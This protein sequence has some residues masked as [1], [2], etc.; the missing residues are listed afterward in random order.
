MGIE[1][2]AGADDSNHAGTNIKGEIALVT[3]SLLSE[4]SVVKTFK[5]TREYSSALKWMA[6]YNPPVRD[7]RFTVLLEDKWRHSASNLVSVSPYLVRAYLK[8]NDIKA[9]PL[10]LY[11]DGY[12][13]AYG[14]R[15][16]R[17]EFGDIEHFVVDNFIKK[18]RNQHGKI[19]KGPRCPTVVYMADI[20]ARMMLDGRL[21]D[22]LQ[23]PKFVPLPARS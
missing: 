6:E 5:N 3:F 15:H 17:Q 21:S 9:D 11:L 7:F 12:M 1:V 14:K 10:K 2:I 8:D 23:H 16:L 13:S 22:L 19:T 20:W 4:D 18:R